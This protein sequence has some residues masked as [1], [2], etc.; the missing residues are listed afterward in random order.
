MI[1]NLTAYKRLDQKKL[2]MELINLTK[3]MHDNITSKVLYEMQHNQYLN[4]ADVRNKY[5]QR[6]YTKFYR[7]MY[8]SE[9]LSY[10]M[11]DLTGKEYISYM[12]DVY[13]PV[14]SQS[15]V[16]FIPTITRTQKIFVNYFENLPY[17]T[18]NSQ[19]TTETYDTL[20]RYYWQTIVDN[21]PDLLSIDVFRKYA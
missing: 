3:A 15:A 5:R 21:T 11:F 19:V 1:L 18:S 14:Y 10:I 17:F 13:I 16:T 12:G 9:Y 4:A 8:D 7:A 20:C 2:R 6:W